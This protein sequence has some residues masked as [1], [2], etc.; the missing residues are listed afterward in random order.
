MQ[1]VHKVEQELDVLFAID[2]LDRDEKYDIIRRAIVKVKMKV[3]VKE[4]NVTTPTTYNSLEN[5]TD[6]SSEEFEQE[7]YSKDLTDETKEEYEEIDPFSNDIRMED[8]TNAFEKCTPQVI[9]IIKIDKTKYTVECEGCK[10][11]F[12]KENDLTTHKR[13]KKDCPEFNP[14]L[15]YHTTM[16]IPTSVVTIDDK[17]VK[18]WKCEKCGLTFKKHSKLKKHRQNKFSCEFKCMECNK[19]F[20]FPFQLRQHSQRFHTVNPKINIPKTQEKK[21]KCKICSKEFSKS[22]RLKRH[23]NKVNCERKCQNCNKVFRSPNLLRSHLVR[24]NECD[25]PRHKCEECT[26]YFRTLELLEVHKLRKRTCV[27]LKC[28]D[29]PKQFRTQRMFD[30]HKARRTTCEIMNPTCENC[31]KWFGTMKLLENHK[32]K[33]F[34]CQQ[35]I[36]CNKCGKL[37]AEKYYERHKISN[38]CQT[39]IDITCKDCYKT[40]KTKNIARMHYIKR[41]TRPA[42]CRL[43]KKCEKCNKN[44]GEDKY[45]IHKCREH[46]II[47]E[48]KSIVHKKCK[49]CFKVFS[50]NKIAE[51][52]FQYR[53]TKPGLCARKV[54]C[55]KCKRKIQEEKYERH[56]TRNCIFVESDLKCPD[57]LKTFIDKKRAKKHAMNKETKCVKTIPCLNCGR[58]FIEE[59]YE[60]HTLH[61]CVE[62]KSCKYCDKMFPDSNAVREHRMRVHRK[63]QGCNKV[64]SSRRCLQRHHELQRECSAYKESKHFNNTKTLKTTEIHLEKETE[65]ENEAEEIKSPDAKTTSV[66]LSCGE[67]QNK[68]PTLW[69]LMVHKQGNCCS[70]AS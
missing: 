23:E 14:N 37:I 9:T 22:H 66:S 68:F 53:H 33:L 55:Q 38:I 31:L 12:A 15:Q 30:L 52:H 13:Q 25:R 70:V 58:K 47:V 24:L 69:A 17:V 42:T 67:C 54:E 36:K 20:E 1:T 35:V 46:K 26:K 44:M 59:S 49:D 3:D 50:T 29:C 63:C 10:N 51:R 6:N 56:K 40:F 21:W 18:I 64:F 61:N 48:E 65:V 32:N 62:R 4:Q 28:E 57:C 2:F 60:K 16:D 8:V 5:Y 45:H 11:V 39:D 27:P 7:N 41:Q 43:M 34:P 19:E